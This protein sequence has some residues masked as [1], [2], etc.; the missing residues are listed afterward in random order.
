MM[1]HLFMPVSYILAIGAA[2]LPALN[3]CIT[4]FLL[5]LVNSLLIPPKRRKLEEF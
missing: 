4:H 2:L 5:F 3:L 1:D